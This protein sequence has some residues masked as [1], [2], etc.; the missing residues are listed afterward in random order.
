MI[1]PR[2]VFFINASLSLI[3]AIL[4]SSLPKQLRPATNKADRKGVFSKFMEGLRHIQTRPLLAAAMIAM[5][6]G[7]LVTFLYDGLI[8]LLVKEIGYSSAMFGAAVAVLGAGG[9]VGALLLGQFG[10]RRNP[11]ILMAAS[12]LIGGILIALIGHIGRGDF[13]MP[14][15]L[16]LATLLAIGIASTGLFVPYRVILQRET[17]QLLL[18]RVAAVGEAAIA[19]ATLLGP[20]IGAALANTAGVPFPFLAGGYVIAVLAIVFAIARKKF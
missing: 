5:T 17:P 16:F 8:A 7:F 2:Q 14:P 11:L 15:V 9:V 13:T 6:I 19:V 4:L 1:E 3:A 10:E 20:P 12:G 18:G